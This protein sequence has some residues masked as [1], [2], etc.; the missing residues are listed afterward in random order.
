MNVSRGFLVIGSIYLVL[1]MCLGLYMG[2]HEDFKLAPLHAHIN[3]V[4]FVLMVLFSLTY[5]VFPAMSGSG[6]ARLH[7][8]MHQIGALL[9]LVGLWLILTGTAVGP[10]MAVPEIVV[11]LGMV[12]F[13]WNAYRNA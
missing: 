5:K 6:L 10:L 2:A 12:I 3:L 13:G 1:G 4:G 8:W 11:I 9:L 7:F